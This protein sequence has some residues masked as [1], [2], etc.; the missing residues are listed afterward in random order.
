M[1]FYGVIIII[2]LFYFFLMLHID[3]LFYIFWNLP[4]VFISNRMN[5]MLICVK[6][7]FLCVVL[8]AIVIRFLMSID[9]YD[10]GMFTRQN[11]HLECVACAGPMIDVNNICFTTIIDTEYTVTYWIN[12]SRY[13]KT[14]LWHSYDTSMTQLWDN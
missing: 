11:V 1:Y 6:H 12:L 13:I 9:E 8:W 4:C 10:R 3:V 7:C 2:V 14:P 5:Y